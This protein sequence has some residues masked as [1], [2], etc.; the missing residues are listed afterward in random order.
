M[1]GERAR[2]LAANPQVVVEADQPL[3]YTPI[4]PV[5]PGPVQVIDPMLAVT[6]EERGGRGRAATA[7]R[8]RGGR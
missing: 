6:L 3:S 7:G 1:P 4:P 8:G 2:A 5:G